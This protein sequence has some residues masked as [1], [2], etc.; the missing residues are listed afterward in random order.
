MKGDKKVTRNDKER[1]NNKEESGSVERRLRT[2]STLQEK[3]SARER[4]RAENKQKAERQ[5]GR[6]GVTTDDSG[7]DVWA[8]VGGLPDGDDDVGGDGNGK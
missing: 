5:T 8:G 4:E 1:Q 6:R 2:E 7:N 3:Q